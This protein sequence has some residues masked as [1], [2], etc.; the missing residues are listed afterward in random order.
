MEVPVIL[1]Q[2]VVI[3]KVRDEWEYNAGSDFKLRGFKVCSNS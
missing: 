1:C 2:L 3:G